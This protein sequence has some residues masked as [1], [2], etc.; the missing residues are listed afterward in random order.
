MA[1]LGKENDLANALAPQIEAQII[2]YITIECGVAPIQPN[3]IDGLAKGIAFGIAPT[4]IAF[5]VANIEVKTSG[6]TT[7]GNQTTQTVTSDTV[8]E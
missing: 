3:C 5:L 7:V 4:L 6:L 8:I 1:I 2:N